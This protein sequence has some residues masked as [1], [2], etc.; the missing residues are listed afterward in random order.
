MGLVSY[1]YKKEFVC[2]QDKMV[3]VPYYS[4]A[5][6]KGLKEESFTFV[7]SKGIERKYY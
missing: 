2:R 7:N 4:T 3:G 5:D 1:V 6:F